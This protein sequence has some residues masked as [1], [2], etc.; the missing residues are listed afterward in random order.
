M[1]SL[2]LGTVQLTDELAGYQNGTGVVLPLGELCSLLE[3]AVHTE[4]GH[5]I[6]EGFVGRAERTFR[7]DIAHRSIR[8]SGK[9]LQYDP[10]FIQIYKNDIYVDVRALNAWFSLGITFDAR[11]SS[12]VVDPKDPLP[13]Q[14]RLQRENLAL[15][16][17]SASH[18]SY[19]DPGFARV[20]NPYQLVGTPVID[21][22]LSFN[23]SAMMGARTT[24]SRYSAQLASDF[25]YGGLNAFLDFASSAT[26]VARL[27]YGLK[28]PSGGLL[29]PLHA[30]EENFGDIESLEVPLVSAAHATTGFSVS[31]VPLSQAVSPDSTTF[32]GP[33]LAT[34]DV[35]L[36]RG[37]SLIGYQA[38]NGRGKYEFKNIPLNLGV[39]KF[40]LEFNG[41]LGERREEIQTRNVVGTLAP[42]A[43]RYAMFL[44]GSSGA[45][46]WTAQS[47][48]GLKRD[49]TA[50]TSLSSQTLDTGSHMYST[51][52]LRGYFAGALFT[53]RVVEDPASGQA[54]QASG[55]W[56]WG[57][58]NVKVTQ[59]TIEGLV[60]NVYGP[61]LN[62][63]KSETDLSF[64]NLA[65]PNWSHL[66]PAELEF[67]RQ[68]TLQGTQDI[69]ASGHISYQRA[70]FGITNISTWESQTGTTGQRTGEILMSHFRGG[71]TL[72]GN[73]TYQWERA[74]SIVS[75]ALQTS[76]MLPGVRTLTL[77]AYESPQSGDI[78]FMGSLNRNAGDY[79]YGMSLNLSKTRGITVG[80]NISYGAIRNPDTA[81]WSTTAE[82]QATRGAVLIHVFHD[83]NGNGRREGKPSIKGVAV[84]VNDSPYPSMTEADGT[85]LIEGLPANKPVDIRVSEPTLE[86]PL[87]VTELPGLRVTPRPGNIQRIEFPV[88]STGEMSGTVSMQ[89]E[90]GA[91]PAAGVLVEIL[92]SN[93]K[94]LKSQ[95]TAFD[96]YYTL[97]R[98]PIGAHVIR[99]K[100]YGI[101]VLK[102]V[103]VPPEGAYLDGIDLALV[104]VS[105]S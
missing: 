2:V 97:T 19:V 4:P 31:N 80:F 60:S 51:V 11:G 87:L 17:G 72:D 81:K 104:P 43:V 3:I 105:H 69:Q 53:A 91:Q 57:R 46:E 58:T 59:T 84:F 70:G 68:E 86:D 30:V 96:G 66:L 101:T 49:L 6:A 74:P 13:L 35:E 62:L 75:L 7:L 52:G 88:V 5:G 14:R 77:G 1:L 10:D 100:A 76:R 44:G 98:V 99:A 26:P 15:L 89:D 42:G 8:V 39:N 63:A 37:S 36:F 47:D 18:S 29:G 50:F 38:E 21:Q 67:S 64:A 82:S 24:T 33:L 12:V 41:P 23:E 22:S 83:T 73:I 103:V 55:Q 54:S 20:P 78:G 94:V 28:D 71:N 61:Q 40:R 32:T 16:L 45:P 56:N 90:G 9:E 27:S 25:E 34:W 95:R 85:L 48:V 102:N 65:L 93:G 92:S 79:A